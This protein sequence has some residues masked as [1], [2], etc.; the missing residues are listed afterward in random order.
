MSLQ[1][2]GISIASVH[3]LAGWRVG[4]LPVLRGLEN[5]DEMRVNAPMLF[6]T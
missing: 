5:K 6:C 2:L 1:E 3:F 4:Q